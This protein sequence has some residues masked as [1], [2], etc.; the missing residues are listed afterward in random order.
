MV[1]LDGPR[2]RVF[3]YLIPFRRWPSPRGYRPNEW[4]QP[5]AT[6]RQGLTWQAYRL[7]PEMIERTRTAIRQHATQYAYSA[8]YLLSFIRP[9]ELF[10]DFPLTSLR[11]D[12]SSNVWS[13]DGADNELHEELT[14]EER[15]AFGG[16]E[17]KSVRLDHDRLVV[18]I[19]FSRP[20]GD[21]VAASVYAFGYRH[22]RPFAQMPK[23]HVQ[24]GPLT[25][26]VE[27]Q[28]RVLPASSVELRRQSR[29]LTLTIPL[30]VLGQ[31][32]RL[33]LNARTSLGDVPLDWTAWRVVELA[34]SR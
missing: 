6:F 17:S 16:I 23:L 30:D 31:P 25:H 11:E 27:D 21:A 28:D 4:L 12:A 22:D 20:L 3:R 19:R 18:T 26:R 14:R 24:L 5:P 7:T 9:N 1:G 34:A 33:L 32:E 29:E 2:W 8:R 15:A 13:G 10:G